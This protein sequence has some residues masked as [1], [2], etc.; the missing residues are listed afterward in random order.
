MEI[1]KKILVTGSE[2]YIGSTLVAKL[3]RLKIP[4]DGLD[5]MY[6]GPG[7]KRHAYHLIREDIRNLD[8]IDLRPY[9]TIIHLAALSNDPMGEL[10]PSLTN[11]INYKATIALAKK[12]KKQGVKRFIF[13]SSC[14]IYGIAKNGIVN[15][16]SKTNPLT[17]YAKSKIAVEKALQKMADESF[18]VCILRNSTVYGY[19]PSLRND[20]VVNNLTSCAFATKQIK[21]MSDGSPWR[22]L[23]DVRDLSD[24]FIAFTKA[25]ASKVNKE[26]F[27]IGFTQN[28]FQVKQIVD[29]IEKETKD[30]DIIFTGEHGSDTRSYKVDFTKFKKAFPKIKCSW[31]LQKSIRDL[32]TNLHTIRF[33]REQF[34]NNRY[35]RITILRQLLSAQKIDKDLYWNH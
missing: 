9:K 30:S 24:I 31:P 32:L 7:N 11:D 12:A 18:C 15:E 21:I 8:A 23:I 19:S 6:Y 17:A 10:N 4:F 28:N 14:S 5:T 22:P 13:S 26:L 2:G 25:R 27:N 20:L 16:N 33:T 29:M 3:L 34:E 1:K 35:A